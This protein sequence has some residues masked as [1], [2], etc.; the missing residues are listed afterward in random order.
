MTSPTITVTA[1]R[2]LFGSFGLLCALLAARVADLQL[3][4]NLT[5]G[6][7]GFS[8]TGLPLGAVGVVAIADQLN[9]KVGSKRTAQVGFGFM[10]IGLVVVP[11]AFSKGTLLSALLVFGAGI[12]AVNKGLNANAVATEIE[13][14]VSILAV[15]HALC[16]LGNAIGGAMTFAFSLAGIAVLPQFVF[17]SVI[18]G[19][20]VCKFAP[21][22]LVE[23]RDTTYKYDRSFE[24]P[25][26]LALILALMSMLCFCAEL[27][28]SDWG[29]VFV[30][31]VLGSSGQRLAPV[32]YLSYAIT[33]MATRLVG[34]SLRRRFS[35]SFLVI[36][37]SGIS[38]VGLT[39]A[40]VVPTAT[41]AILAGVLCGL[42]LALTVPI[43]FRAAGA[44]QNGRALAYATTTGTMGTVI[45]PPIAGFIAERY[46][47]PAV[48]F[49]PLTCSV[50]LAL[51]G[52]FVE[53]PF[54]PATKPDSV[55]ATRVT[56]LR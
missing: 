25:S 22:L 27:S 38:A 15:L 19:A 4:I 34:D 10:L 46:G 36:V 7:L 20:F 21:D 44:V 56:S 35:L 1:L 55:T 54:I 39:V 41:T 16:P 17:F 49:L 50:G 33:M 13:Y 14:N 3:H 52:R 31:H 11:L 42:G 30:S 9:Q 5:A 53:R 43:I 8:L 29:T 2:C 37:G 28:W 24:R 18:I 48:L 26:L 6:E 40:L 32:G 51:L 12:G 45:A 23:R 47:T